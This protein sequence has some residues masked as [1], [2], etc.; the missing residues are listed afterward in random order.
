MPPQRERPLVLVIDDVESILRIIQLEL[1]IH[2][3]D[4]VG[5]E[6]SDQVYGAIELM[7]PDIIVFEVFLPQIGGPELLRGIRERWDTPVIF[8]TTS[9]NDGDREEA[10]NLGAND[11]ILKPF[12][13]S[14]LTY[15]ISALL[16]MPP[17]QARIL[18]A[19]GLEIDFSRRK[20]H[21]NG[22]RISPSTNEWAILFALGRQPG[23]YMPAEDIL[24]Q[25]WGL[26][27]VINRDNL[28]SLVARLR[29]RLG[30]D[31]QRPA[32]IVG[33]M[34]QGFTLQATPVEDAPTIGAEA[35][36]SRAE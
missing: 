21:R 26:E 27:G 9:E 7:D 5:I 28:L 17:L 2:G 15:R 33:D 32:V 36:R 23:S 25:V 13:P 31:A 10:L 19:D 3:F 12:D 8:L 30:D 4:V 18:T 34:E 11:Y 20:A 29:E 22:K 16:K 35:T 14:E 24:L 6:I 1:R